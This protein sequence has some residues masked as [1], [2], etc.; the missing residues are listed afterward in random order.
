MKFQTVFTA[1]VA[2]A[3]PMAV[4]AED[5]FGGKYPYCND[6][7]A[8][9]ENEDGLWNYIDH[10]WCKV[11]EEKCN[12]INTCEP[13]D[14]Y[15][16]C[17][18]TSIPVIYIDDD[19]S[20]GIED[21]NWCIISN[22][23]K[24]DLDLNV[25][26]WLDLMPRPYVKDSDREAYF[27]IGVNDYDVK[28]FMKEYEITEIIVNGNQ[29]STKKIYPD[30]HFGFRFDSIYYIRGEINNIKFTIKN[31]ETNQSFNEEYNV[32]LRITM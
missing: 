2:L 28:T 25:G 30:T 10:T 26:A 31:K 15:P 8:K 22:S 7:E 19:G 20:W 4:V 11:N 13:V 14:D 6:C 27:Y 9:F 18:D 23:P 5:L 12:S 17:K 1:F 21:N 16:C 32:N 24:L 3:T 29:V